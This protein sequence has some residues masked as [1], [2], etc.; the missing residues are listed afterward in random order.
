M[1][2]VLGMVSVKWLGGHVCCRNPPY[3]LSVS[4]PATHI[5]YR[6]QTIKIVGTFAVPLSPMPL[7]FDAIL[8][9]NVKVPCRIFFA[10]VLQTLLAY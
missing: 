1:A 4:K 7:T 3:R 10:A 6:V 9:K 2:E 8:T 5:T